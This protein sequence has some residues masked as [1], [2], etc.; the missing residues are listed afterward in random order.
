[1]C[2]TSGRVDQCPKIDLLKSQTL[3]N[4]GLLYSD[5]PLKRLVSGIESSTCSTKYY[6]LDRSGGFWEEESTFQIPRPSLSPDRC[7]CVV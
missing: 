6:V 1:M 2:G 3:G 5:S 4:L 7:Q